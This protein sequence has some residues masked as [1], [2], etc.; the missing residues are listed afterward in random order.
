MRS[1]VEKPRTTIGWKG[2]VNDPDLDDS[3]DIPKGVYIARELMT[4]LTDLGLPVASELLSPLVEPYLEDLLSIGFIGA[5]TTESQLHR[6]MVSALPFPVGFKNGT[7]SS[8]TVAMDAIVAARASH[9]FLATDRYGGTGITKSAGNPDCFAVLR[10][11]SNGPNYHA[12]Q[13]LEMTRMLDDKGIP[14]RL[15]IDCSH[16]NSQKDYRK[17]VDVASEVA[18]QI[19]DTGSVVGVMLESH[20]QPGMLVLHSV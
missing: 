18:E 19:R 16:G 17:Q 1:Y 11:G 4:Q 13:V 7:D 8:L 12:E 14:P 6:E 9:T 20:L 15:V 3:C 10:G 5:R 2:L